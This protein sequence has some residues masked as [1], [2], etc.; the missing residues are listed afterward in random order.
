M[1]KVFDGVNFFG[2]H[3]HF[4]QIIWRNIQ[5]LELSVKYKDNK[6][7][8]LFVRSFLAL[9]YVPK[10]EM[11]GKY[12]LICDRYK[13]LIGCDE[14]FENFRAY[15]YSNW[16]DNNLK[17]ALTH[18]FSFWSINHRILFDLPTTTNSLEAWHRSFNANAVI[19]HPN[20]SKFI[21]LLQKEETKICALIARLNDGKCVASGTLKKNQIK[22]IL[23][24]FRYYKDLEF[25]EAVIRNTEVVFD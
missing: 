11:E 16:I 18:S 19:A 9:S 7:F 24:N 20:L 12:E 2:C 15:F 8:R 5:S 4:G 13:R 6:E 10:L 14:D 17:R 3:F 23:T 25:I 22:N 1:K 21:C